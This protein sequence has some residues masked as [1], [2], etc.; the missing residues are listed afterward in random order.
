MQ[1][2][3]YSNTISLGI[4][5][6]YI[7]IEHSQEPLWL[8]DTAYVLVNGNDIN[9]LNFSLIGFFI[10]D[11]RIIVNSP[12]LDRPFR[13]LESYIPPSMSSKLKARRQE[14][15]EAHESYEDI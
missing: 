14:W 9:T 12:F 3:H 7:G 6:T 5:G 13:L 15:N 4:G 11:N 8:D 2:F 10:R 1:T